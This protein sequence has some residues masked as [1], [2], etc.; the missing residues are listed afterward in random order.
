MH[1]CAYMHCRGR[2]KLNTTT[3]MKKMNG[4]HS[5][6]TF[7]IFVNCVF[8]SSGSGIWIRQFLYEQEGSKF[9][10]NGIN[11]IWSTL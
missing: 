8:H 2:R 9:H 11:D 3:Y 6:V 7:D 5:S 10:P 4:F 1:P